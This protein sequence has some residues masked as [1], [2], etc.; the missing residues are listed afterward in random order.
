MTAF[1]QFV[2][3]LFGSDYR[4]RTFLI[5]SRLTAFFVHE[6]A[7]VESVT[8]GL[9]SLL[10]TENGIVHFDKA[11]ATLKKVV[12]SDDYSDY[13]G[14]LIG[15]VA[16]L[17]D[18]RAIDPLLRDVETGNM[19]MCGVAFFGRDAL[20]AVLRAAQGRD[21]LERSSATR[22]LFLMLEPPASR[23][24]DAQSRARIRSALLTG[25]R[26]DSPLVRATAVQGLAWFRDPE[27]VAVL[28]DIANHDTF[29]RRGS[30]G[31]LGARVVANAAKEA[32]NGPPQASCPQ[33]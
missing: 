17:R 20:D 27:V 28:D 21:E 11:G 25:A 8:K 9:I 32:L 31:A 1:R 18:R 16:G 3:V 10:E 7:L 23:R 15:T 6:P 30:D 14:D 22:V 33:D 12:R 2:D 13:L 29:A 4:G 5:R 24:I 26:D 19:A